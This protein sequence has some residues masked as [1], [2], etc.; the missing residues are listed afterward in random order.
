MRT[1]Y[2][3]ALLDP[4]TN[5]P[6]YIGKSCDPRNRFNQH[7]SSSRR[8][9]WPVHIWM[10]SLSRKGLLPIMEVV[11]ICGD[12]WPEVETHWISEI[13]KIPGSRLLNASSGGDGHDFYSDP[14]DKRLWTIKKKMG[15]Y[16]KF[17]RAHGM[18]DSI[19][20][21]HANMRRA[22]KMRPDLFGRWKNVGINA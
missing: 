7:V 16:L 11:D 13:K 4:E 10:A 22:A 17:F 20:K 1:A 5:E 21:A 6:R 3:Y 9:A 2:I 18:Q 8:P 14:K 12:D 19:D 15:D